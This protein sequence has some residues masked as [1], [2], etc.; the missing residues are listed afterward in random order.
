MHDDKNI[1]ESWWALSLIVV[2][3]MGVRYPRASSALL[4]ALFVA[5]NTSTL[6]TLGSKYSRSLG[7]VAARAAAQD[8]QSSEDIEDETPPS[9]DAPQEAA[10]DTARESVSA[11]SE[12]KDSM[13][14]INTPY[15]KSSRTMAPHNGGD[16]ET[17]RQEYM[18]ARAQTF[19]THHPSAAS[20]NRRLDAAYDDLM[21]YGMKRDVYMSPEDDDAVDSCT[22]LPINGD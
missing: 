10:Q 14:T 5:Y 8:A 3:I 4:I 7:R 9:N 22:Q 18:D 1:R 19:K 6:R 16:I 15:S 12:E 11:S 21:K 13:M 20:L 17:L 2:V